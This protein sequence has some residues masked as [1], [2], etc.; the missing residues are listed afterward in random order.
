[1]QN[2]LKPMQIALKQL[3]DMEA[4]HDVFPSIV[5]SNDLSALRAEWNKKKKV[6]Q[7]DRYLAEFSEKFDPVVRALQLETRMLTS[8]KLAR[9][10]EMERI[11]KPKR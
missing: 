11:A 2:A 4:D 1:M 6:D 5:S 3:D 9:D 8:Q 7:F 10:Q